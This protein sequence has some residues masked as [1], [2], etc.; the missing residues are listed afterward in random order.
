MGVFRLLKYIQENDGARQ[1]VQLAELAK[2]KRKQ[3]GKNPKLVCDYITFKT[4]LLA[5]VD[6]ALIHCEELPDYALLY[7]GN[8]QLY[9]KRVQLFVRTFRQLGID[10]VFF[11]DGPLGINEAELQAKLPE[12]KKRYQLCLQ[13]IATEAEICE[14]KKDSTSLVWD[15]PQLAS[16]QVLMTLRDAGAQIIICQGEAD[17]EIAQYARSHVEVLGIL[18]TDTDF[19]IMENT[20]LFPIALNRNIL[21]IKSQRVLDKV[22]CEAVSPTTLASSL[23]LEEQQLP[24]LSILCGNDFTRTLNRQLDVLTELELDSTDVKSIAQWLQGEKYTTDQVS[25]NA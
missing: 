16:T 11:V 5:S 8:Y 13:R 23:G 25:A 21:G 19:S 2:R 24:D 17:M 1:K 18:S 6:F 22:V 7:G 12:Q 14:Q 4:Q 15:T 9:G 10:L 3:T 20:T